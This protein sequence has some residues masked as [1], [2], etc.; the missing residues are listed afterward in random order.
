MDLFL[1]V[2]SILGV[3]V[4]GMIAYLLGTIKAL[5]ATIKEKEKTDQRNIPDYAILRVLPVIKQQDSPKIIELENEI[6]S[7]TQKLD[8]DFEK[9]KR[10]RGE[11]REKL[12]QRYDSIIHEI[13]DYFIKETDRELFNESLSGNKTAPSV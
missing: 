10:L 6:D 12:E 2:S 3:L 1:V 11:D 5:R 7:I 4:A 9:D 8:W 13:V